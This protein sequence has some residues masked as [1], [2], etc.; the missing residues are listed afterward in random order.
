MQNDYTGMLGMRLD[1]VAHT[2][3]IHPLMRDSETNLIGDELYLTLRHQGLAFVASLDGNV[4]SIQFFSDGHQGHKQFK[5]ALPEGILFKDSR[6]AVHDRLGDP[7]VS[8]GGMVM[9]FLGKVPKWDR[10]DRQD[11]SLHIQYAEDESS[12]CLVSLMRP[13]AVPV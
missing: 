6:S 3:T 12:V 2:A 7:D 8:G 9:H 10:Y 4:S 5:D 11:Y 1:D 13:D